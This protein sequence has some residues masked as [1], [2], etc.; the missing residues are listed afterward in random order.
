MED[1]LHRTFFHHHIDAVYRT[2]EGTVNGHGTSATDVV[3]RKE[4]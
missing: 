4:G 1:L 2:R 3:D